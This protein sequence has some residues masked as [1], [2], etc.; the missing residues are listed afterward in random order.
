MRD[1]AS[2]LVFDPY[3]YIKDL[4]HS[5]LSMKD[6]RVEA[7]FIANR[8]RTDRESSKPIQRKG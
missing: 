1:N 2:N 7:V 5:D 8:E 3:F 6:I 4:V